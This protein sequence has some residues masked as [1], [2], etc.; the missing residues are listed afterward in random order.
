MM[1]IKEGTCLKEYPVIYRIVESLYHTPETNVTLYVNYIGIKKKK[2]KTCL[3]FRR[4]ISI[5]IVLEFWNG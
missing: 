1:G 5:V 3:E 2:K 4:L